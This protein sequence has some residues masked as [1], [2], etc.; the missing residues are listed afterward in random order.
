MNPAWW[1][2]AARLWVGFTDD[3]HTEILEGLTD[4]DAVV[5]RGQRSLKDGAAVKILDTPS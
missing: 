5:T 4:G 3:H 1:P 2:I